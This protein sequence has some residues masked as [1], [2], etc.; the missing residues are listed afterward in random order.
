MYMP[1]SEI[2]MFVSLQKLEWQSH[3]ACMMQ[4]DGIAKQASWR[5]DKNLACSS[6][7]S[8]FPETPP[9]WKTLHWK[10]GDVAA[11]GPRKAWEAR[12]FLHGTGPVE[13][14]TS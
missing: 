10:S 1:C 5:M 2:H 6:W 4:R 3:M 7:I 12:G 14:Y 11:V 8:F 13:L 9:Q